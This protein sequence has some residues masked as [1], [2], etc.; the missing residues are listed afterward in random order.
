MQNGN[1][2]PGGVFGDVRGRRFFLVGIGGSGM[3]PLAMIL[4]GRGAIVAG[5]D[6]GLD[7]GRV[8]AKFDALRGQGI[9]LFA[10]DG[11]GV[12]SAEQIVV[13][14][15]AVEDTV[16]DMVAAARI[17]CARMTRAELNAA[18]FNAAALP[19]GV[20]GTSGKSTVTG[21]IATILHQTGRD[22]S[23]MNGAVMKDFVAADRPF[24]SALV[25]AGDAY[26]SEVD[27]SDGSIALYRPHV[28]V[29][30]NVSLDH[31]ALDELNILFGDFI[32]H[33]RHAVVN[34]DNADAAAL[35]MTLPASRV[36]R[37]SVEGTGD[38]V[39][40]DLREEPFAV[41]FMLHHDG[42]TLPVRLQVPGRHNVSNALAA[43]G[44]AMAAGVPLSDAAAALA[45]FT[46]LRRRFDL[47][48]DAG[49]VSVIDDFG[50]NPDK[51]AATLD[52]LHAFPGRLLVLFQPHG[53]GPLKVMRAELVAMFANTL[54]VDDL[55]VMPDP[56]Y[57]GGTT[58]RE[59]TSADIVRD[60]EVSGRRALHIPDR[61]A[62]AAH[63][64]AQARA[65]DR[66]VVMGARDDTL[67]LLAAEMVVQLGD[68]HA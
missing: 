11:S 18:L 29:L 28:A 4:A 32:A 21:M 49:G 41:S 46:G 30:N 22:P 8:P 39:A 50:H 20:A 25:G 9:E 7:Q 59:V 67:S 64:V 62:A 54:A 34:A 14:S 66:I 51:I 23:V 5:S 68:K 63:L 33:T 35:A 58:N 16:A 47:V 13:A 10:Q 38:L 48:G 2:A 61:A 55:L 40:R 37:F 56:V 27:E 43:L 15:A 44:A 57:H 17:G 53:F 36:T 42:G 60:V 31:K 24:A 45:C 26:V 1:A 12:V 6:R 52:T 65:G 3:M 19:I